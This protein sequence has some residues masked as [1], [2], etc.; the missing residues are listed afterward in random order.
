MSWVRFSGPIKSDKVSQHRVTAAT[1]HQRC[2]A[3]VLI[4]GDGPAFRYALQRNTASINKILTL[5]EIQHIYELCNIKLSGFIAICA[6]C[7]LAYDSFQI[8]NDQ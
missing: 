4:R 6:S 5:R 2:V 7:L 3:L 8:F 1:F